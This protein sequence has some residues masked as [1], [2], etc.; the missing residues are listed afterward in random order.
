M[1]V[2]I[3]FASGKVDASIIHCLCESESLDL[4]GYARDTVDAADRIV[5]NEPQVVIIDSRHNNDAARTVLRELE[6]LAQV[7]TIIIISD[8]ATMRDG[9]EGS[10]EVV[11]HCFQFPGEERG[12]CAALAALSA[13]LDR[14]HHQSRSHQ[15]PLFTGFWE[16]HGSQILEALK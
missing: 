4:I 10:M 13:E 2:F 6:H 14:E 12:F 1:T 15:S 3:V 9:Q 11:T 7:P 16:G 5:K 8:S